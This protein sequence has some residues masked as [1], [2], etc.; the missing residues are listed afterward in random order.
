MNDERETETVVPLLTLNY[1]PWRR[2]SWG[3]SRTLNPILGDANI[4][5]ADTRSV[6]SECGAFSRKLFVCF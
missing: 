4:T 6:L 2:T 1:N 5:C 3:G